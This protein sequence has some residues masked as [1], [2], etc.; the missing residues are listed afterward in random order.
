MKCLLM[1]YG[2][3]LKNKKIPKGK[4]KELNAYPMGNEVQL[5]EF[6]AIRNKHENELLKL[7]QSMY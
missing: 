1:G 2:G 5:K 7:T 3:E 4:R 6:L